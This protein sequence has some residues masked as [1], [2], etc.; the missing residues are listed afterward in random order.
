M[1]LALVWGDQVTCADV[2]G[3]GL[4]WGM[5]AALVVLMW[6]RVL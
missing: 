1:L 5:C 4:E 3:I 6:F 2:R